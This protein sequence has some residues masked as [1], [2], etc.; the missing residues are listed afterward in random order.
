MSFARFEFGF[1]RSALRRESRGTIRTMRWALAAIAL[2]VSCG[3]GGSGNGPAAKSDVGQA[4]KTPEQL[5]LAVV[6][7]P[8]LA[9]SISR[10]QGEWKAQTGIT[11]EIAEIGVE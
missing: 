5:R 7:D 4:P 8:V 10:L 2:A 6:D 3:C 1:E 9:K 11:L